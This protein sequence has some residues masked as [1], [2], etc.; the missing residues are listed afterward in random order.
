MYGCTAVPPYLHSLSPSGTFEDAFSLIAAHEQTLVAPLLEYLRGRYAR[1]VRIVGDE[2]SG[3][4]RVPTVSFVVVG[5]R[6]IR[7]PDVV[8]V[9]DAK[10]GVSIISTIMLLPKNDTD[11]EL[12]V[13]IRYGHFYAYTLVGSLEPKVDVEDG[14]V[15][16]S[17]VHYNTT[18]EVTRV[19]SILDEVLA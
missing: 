1:G 4:T 11:M 13:G 14:V 8:R 16:I 17:F 15:R 12:Q 7:S 9:V 6:A 2:F 5:E 18:E 3:P 10:G 19:I